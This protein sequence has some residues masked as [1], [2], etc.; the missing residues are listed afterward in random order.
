MFLSCLCCK[1]IAPRPFDYSSHSLTFKSLI[2]LGVWIKTVR[3]EQVV[4][5]CFRKYR[6]KE[7]KGLLFLIITQTMRQ[8]HEKILQST[9]HHSHSLHFSTGNSQQQHSHTC[10]SIWIWKMGLLWSPCD[11][12]NHKISTLFS[13]SFYSLPWNESTTLVWTSTESLICEIKERIH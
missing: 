8:N 12:P 5:D 1:L 13:Y 11:K 6:H 2:V 3:T 7:K 9:V 10:S 4:E